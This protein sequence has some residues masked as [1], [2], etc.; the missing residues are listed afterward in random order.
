MTGL[1]FRR[2]WYPLIAG[3]LI[4]VVFELALILWTTHGNFTYTLDDPYIHLALSENLA[5]FGHYGLN[6]E[7]YSSPSSSI[8][9]PLLLVPFLAVGFGLYAPIILNIPFAIATVLIIHQILISSAE[10]HDRPA[11]GISW[12]CALFIFFVVNGFGVIFTG[13][14]HSLHILVTAAVMYFINRM[15][16]AADKGRVVAAGAYDDALL[17]LCIVLSSLVRFEGLAVSL[18]AIVML[19]KLGKP[20]L[21]VVSGAVVILSLAAY[22]YAMSKLGLPW[23]PSSVLTKSRAAADLTAQADLG[24]KVLAAVSRAAGSSIASLRNP[25]A[26]LLLAMTVLVVGQSI[27]A[28]WARERVSPIYVAGIVAVVCLHFAFGKFGWYGRY[29]SYVCVFVICAALYVFS[30]FLFKQAAADTPVARERFAICAIIGALI[31]VVLGVKQSIEPIITTP[32]AAQNIYE[33]QRQMHDFVTNHWKSRVAVNDVGYV[34]FQNDQYVLDIWGLASEEARQLIRADDP[35][36]LGKLAAK[37]NVRL[38]II[39]DK[40]FYKIIPSDWLKVA[41][42]RLSTTTVTPA[43]GYV[44]FYVIGIDR[45]LCSQVSAQLTEFA[46]TLARPRTLAVDA[47]ACE[48]PAISREAEPYDGSSAKAFTRG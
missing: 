33:Q 15:Q 21:A 22:F 7:E 25:E 12:A 5:R 13:M 16:L 20:R 19:I 39:Y 14:E 34:G 8:F 27:R 37:H 42:L 3:V 46:A 44:S 11:S 4:V 45:A 47:G 28:W 48:R 17:A 40:Y 35:D 9:W 30:G 24:G 31:L 18:F 2:D 43:D 26:L 23:L 41:E 1:G 29:Q 32:V 10:A 38:A 6:L 36:R